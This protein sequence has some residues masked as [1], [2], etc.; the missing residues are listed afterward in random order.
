MAY[1]EI[2]AMDIWEILRRYKTGHNLSAIKRGLGYDRKTVR[3]FIKIAHE[4]PHVFESKE[5]AIGYFNDYVEKHTG[6]P[7]SKQE[8]LKKYH[9]ELVELVTDKTHPL[10]AKHAFEVLIDR[11]PELADVSYTSFKRYCSSIHYQLYPDKS[12]CRIETE[13]GQQIQIDYV[14]VGL[15]YDP[16]SKKRRVVYA[17]IGTLSHSRHKYTEFTFKQ[18]QQSFVESHVKMFQFFGGVAH[19]IVIDNL[20]AGVIKPDLY[21]PKLNRAYREMAEYYGCF[22]D[23]ARVATPKDKPKVERDAQTIK[24]QFKKMIVSNSS[25]TLNIANTTILDW[26]VY[27]YGTRKHGTTKLEPMQVFTDI[28]QP[29]LLPLPAERYQPAVWKEATVHPDHY[30]QVNKKAYSVPHPYVGK[31]VMVKVTSKTVEIYHNEQIIKTHA[32]APPG[33][34]RQTD[35]ADFPENMQ[36]VLDRGLHRKLIEK[37]GTVGN[38]FKKLITNLLQQH[39]FIKLRCAQGLISMT[40]KYDLVHVEEAA[41]IA[42]FFDGSMTPKYFKQIIERLIEEQEELTM[43]LPLSDETQSFIRPDDYYNQTV[44]FTTKE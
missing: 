11:H 17:F 41:G 35:P 27:T 26:L 22:I 9:N 15:L 8:K 13:P 37:A 32:I 25:L 3:K 18:T 36:Y 39:A 21:D 19:T 24:D 44:L 5:N 29:A 20:K 2:T 40:N 30:I 14:K 38:N 31:K 10:K 42:L 34:Y 33:K 1:K 4:N 23:P 16:V 6:C 28:E 43:E 12:T 7:R